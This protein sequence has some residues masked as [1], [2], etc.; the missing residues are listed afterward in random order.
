MRRREGGSQQYG[1]GKQARHRRSLDRATSL[2]DARQQLARG[3]DL[4]CPGIDPPDRLARVEHVSAGTEEG[5]PSAIFVNVE[6]RTRRIL[7]KDVS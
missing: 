2:V 4:E 7:D 5:S 1:K 6:A 3:R